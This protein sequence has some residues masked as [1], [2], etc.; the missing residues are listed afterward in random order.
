VLATCFA[1][2]DEEGGGHGMDWAAVNC[3]E[4]H[5]I[6]LVVERGNRSRGFRCEAHRPGTQG[7][8]MLTA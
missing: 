7:S 1:S 5:H 8:G 3:A 4:D 6:G 2:R